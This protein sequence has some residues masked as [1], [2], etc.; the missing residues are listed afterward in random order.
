MLMS[1]DTQET[2][3]IYNRTLGTNYKKNTIFDDE[4]ISNNG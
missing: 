2:N 4:K 3:I 1:H